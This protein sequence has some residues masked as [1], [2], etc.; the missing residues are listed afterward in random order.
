MVVFYACTNE[1][2]DII[3]SNESYKIIKTGAG[4][5]WDKFVEWTVQNNLYGIEN[6]SLIPGTT[7]CHTCT[8]HWR[9]RS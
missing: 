5:D 8:K 4:L 2:I 6:L 9:I 3:E 7:G 1:T